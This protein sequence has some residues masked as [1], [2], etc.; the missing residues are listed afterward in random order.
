MTGTSYEKEDAPGRLVTSTRD[1]N[2]EKEGP[3]GGLGKGRKPHRGR[4]A[5]RWVGGQQRTRTATRRWAGWGQQ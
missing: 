3:R 1:G 5:G 4:Q 2:R